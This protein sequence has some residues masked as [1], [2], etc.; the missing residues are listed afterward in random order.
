MSAASGTTPRTLVAP[1]IALILLLGLLA[2]PSPAAAE[3]QCVSDA[4]G[5][6]EDRSDGSMSGQP[7]A[8]I[9]AVC[10]SHT[11]DQ[12]GVTV[13]VAQPTDP[14]TDPAWEDFQSAIGVAV[15]TDGDG[16]EEYDINYGRFPDGVARVAVFDH[17]SG[18]Q[19]CTGTGTFNDVRYL[20]Q[21]PRSCVGN[22]QSLNVAAFIFYSSNVASQTSA[23]YFDEIPAYPELIGPFST[24]ADPDTPVERLEGPSR[25]DTAIAVSQDTFEDGAAQA[26]VLARAELFPDALVA[27]PLAVAKDAPLLLT[28]SFAVAQIVEDEIRRVLPEG[29]TVYLSGG[30]AALSE[31]VAAEIEA[32]GYTVERLAG[33]TR[34]ETAVAVADAAVAEPGLIV[35][36]D[37]N[38]FPDAL[39]GG[40]L[41]AFEGGVEIISNGAQLDE[42]ATAYLEAHPEAEVVAVGAVAAEAVPEATAIVGEDIFATSVAVAEARYPDVTGVGIASGTNFP[43]GL[44]GGANAAREGIPLLL[45]W[46]DVL[47]DVVAAYLAEVAPLESVVMYGGEAALSHQTEADAAAALG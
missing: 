32:L 35:V 27:A 9:L 5:D 4:Q 39:V 19:V 8:D 29:G 11:P 37:G 44:A 36:A 28:P 25:V 38:T 17:E 30:T 18:E 45:S 7:E 33:D 1:L 43:D 21:V 40:S 47:P 3:S 22:P 23:G 31:E 34:Y 10:T 20:L 24:A 46:P 13:R 14:E 12:L 2:V 16:V 41:A 42:S 6:V 26:V 15:D